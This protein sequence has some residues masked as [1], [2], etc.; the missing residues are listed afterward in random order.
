M[1]PSTDPT[2]IPYLRL[3]PEYD[4]LRA[5]WFARID[6]AGA[7]GAFILGPEVEAF[8]REAAAYLG[9]RHAIGVANGTEALVL[10]LRA[11]DIGPGDE[12]ITTP[13]TFYATAEA[14]S[15][16]GATPVFVDI[17]ERSFNLDP[18]AVEAAIRPATRAI[19]PVHLFGHPADM[20]ALA[21]LAARHDLKLIED[22]AQAFGARH[23]GRPVG[24]LGDCGCF[25][26]YPTKVLGCY[27]DGGLIC[28]NDKGVHERLLRLRNHGAIAPFL[29]AEVGYNSRLDAIQAALLRLKL[30][31]LDKAVAERQRIARRYDQGLADCD[32]I[33]PTAPADGGHAYNLYTLRHP[34]RDALRE[35]LNAQRI[36]NSQCYPEPLHLQAVHAGLGYRPGELPVVERLCKETLSLPIFPGLRNDEIDR[37]CAL[38]RSA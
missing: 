10:S 8:E 22:A 6:E 32:A 20:D 13:F 11:L 38:V 23:H 4:A 12:V 17:D 29:H 37:I 1:T 36:G 30:R 15:L 35:R 26:F 28:T 9:A 18:A 33:P 21:A 27:G 3:Q 24:A 14:I 25:S 2:P 7:N 34:R 31:N 5:D 19:L 16:V